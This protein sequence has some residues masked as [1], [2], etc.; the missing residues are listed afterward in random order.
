[1]MPFER[2]IYDAL[3]YYIFAQMICLITREKCL[4][5]VSGIHVKITAEKYIY[6]K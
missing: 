4:L 6:L 1:M 3:I 2:S 5:K